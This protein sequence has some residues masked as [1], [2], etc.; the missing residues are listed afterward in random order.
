MAES[1]VTKELLYD[2]Y[3]RCREY[4][5]YYHDLDSPIVPDEVY[6]DCMQEIKRIENMHPEWVRS[7]SPL[8]YISGKAS[9]VKLSKVKHPEQINS[10]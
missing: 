7:D 4:G 8:K 6:D 3:R 5:H 10:V 9:K 1:V 2:L